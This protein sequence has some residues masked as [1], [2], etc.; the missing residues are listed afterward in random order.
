MSRH[1]VF[2]WR[3]SLIKARNFF[4]AIEYSCVATE[5]GLNLMGFLCGDIVLLRCDRK[6]QDMGFP[7]R[8]LAFYVVTVGNGVASQQ[9]RAFAR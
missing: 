6:F 9:G 8:D 3:Q 7:C 1:S 4:V 5:F 2:M